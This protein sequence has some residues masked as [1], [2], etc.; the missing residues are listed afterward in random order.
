MKRAETPELYVLW[1]H[2]G[3]AS[4]LDQGVRSILDNSRIDRRR[5]PGQ[6]DYQLLRS[7]L[8][9]IQP[10][11]VIIDNADEADHILGSLN[12]STDDDAETRFDFIPTC[13]HGS[14]LLTTRN[15][16]V[17]LRMVQQHNIINMSPMDRDLASSLMRKKLGTQEPE[18]D[19]R[20]LV[21]ALGC[22]PLAMTQ[23]AA[24]IRR[25]SPRCSVRLY[26]DSLHES[27]QSKVDLLS[28]N[29]ADSQRDRKANN[30]IVQTW[31]ISFDHISRE[32]PSAA[33][34]LGLMSF[35]DFQSIPEFL[36]IAGIK[37]A[38]QNESSQAWEDDEV[39]VSVDIEHSSRKNT[40]NFA[41]N[42]IEKFQIYSEDTLHDDIQL[43]R[44][45]SFI[46]VPVGTQTFQMH[47]LVQL[48]TQEW[49]RKNGHHETL[50]QLAIS[51]L[52]QVYP[53]FDEF[54]WKLS[55]EIQ[56]L[57]PH[58]MAILLF[59]VDDTTSLWF[60]ARLTLSCGSYY[61]YIE[62]YETAERLL[63]RA[64]PTLR[65][66]GGDEHP[67]T[68]QTLDNLAITYWGRGRP[69]HSI[70][71]QSQVL[72][73]L[74]RAH[75]LADPGTLRSMSNLAAVY[76]YQ[77]RHNDAYDLMS[78]V[79]DTSK[80][81][82]GDEHPFTLSAMDMLASV[83]IELGRL[84]EAGNLQSHV[85]DTR[86][87]LGSND[88][89]REL[90]TMSTLA[91]LYKASNREKEARD[92]Y[93]ELWENKMALLG[94]DH[95]ATSQAL[96]DF[97]KACRQSQPLP[98][99][100]NH[101]LDIMSRREK[102][103]G[104]E[105]PDALADKR[106]LGKYYCFRGQFDEAVSILE[107]TLEAM[108]RVFGLENLSTLGTSDDLAMCYNEQG[109][110]VEAKELGEDTL[111]LKLQILGADHSSTLITMQNLSV[112]LH[113]FGHKA[114]AT[115]MMAQCAAASEKMLGSS[116]KDTVKRRTILREFE[117]EAELKQATRS[118]AES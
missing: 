87:R 23:A 77:G 28:T 57:I 51:H 18:E 74:R 100:E 29:M 73:A 61:A 34:V 80:C 101:I 39:P 115:N 79:L 52:L 98:E 89:L 110:L 32:R 35:H 81:L 59:E 40:S 49:L 55:Q 94:L 64:L 37:H 109:R 9:R 56:P 6:N 45:F 47:A 96:L 75:G 108:K 65:R 54:D 48:V 15:M 72:D 117:A 22:M 71:I 46:S 25:R 5:E 95:S 11:L 86:K 66:L 85:V 63:L 106:I 103:Q 2:A 7:W 62:Q 44:D 31:Q 42:V 91:R 97:G 33:Q 21:V 114:P 111:K 24:Y 107:P 68:L 82:H 88:P 4:R 84:V 20:Q 30:S 76:K 99:V 102:V 69:Q 83:C 78:T 26:L 19:I 70:E 36:L 116:H 118:D 13:N 50:I 3:S 53:S 16:D 67:M 8:I 14:V 90:G 113:D 93:L 10:W 112:Y 17:A 1:L 12:S 41:R 43:L 58:L 38:M 27:R 60:Q 92:L 104:V 105:H